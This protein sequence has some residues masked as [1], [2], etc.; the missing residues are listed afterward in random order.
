MQ[1]LKELVFILKRFQLKLLNPNGQQVERS[2][3]L[4]QLYDALDKNRIDTDEQAET[5]LYPDKKSGSKYRQLKS[6]L[7]ERMLNAI[8]SFDPE[9]MN[10]SDYQ[11]AYYECHKEW[12]V[13]KILSGQ[14]ANT[15][16]LSLATKLLKEVEFY[17]FS[18]L[19]VDIAAYLR[20]QYG[21]RESNDKKFNEYHH[22]YVFQQSVYEAECKAEEYYTF[23]MVKQVN[24]RSAKEEVAL[25]AENQ[26]DLI[27][28]FLSKFNTYKLHLY[29]RLIGLHRFTARNKYEEALAYCLE[30]VAFFQQKKYEAQVP[31][32]IFSYQMLIC[33]IQLRQFEEGDKVAGVCMNFSNEGTFNWFKYK[34]LYLQLSFHA[35]RFDRGAEIL[36]E[37]LAHPRFQFLPDNA[38]EIWRIY[39]SYAYFLFEQGKLQGLKKNS[40]KLGKFINDTPIFSKDKAGLN[41]AIIIIK[42]LYLLQQRK[43]G[44]L[45][46]EAEAIEHYCYRYLRNKNTLRSYYFIRMLLQ[47]PTGQFDVEQINKKTIKYQRL[48]AENPIS[49]ANQIYE[50]EIVPYEILWQLALESVQRK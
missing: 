2:S 23:L 1:D 34:E 30:T 29:G 19:A 32:Q 15:A 26:Y 20:F 17:E 36:Q 10:M 49:I 46:D 31:I 25:L 12:L 39:E 28:P 44:Q 4:G 16:A 41:I 38:K 47:I 7:R 13:V 33:H 43:L 50:I 22:I 11:K 45:L 48:L 24:N 37:V 3:M 40:F 8:A 5:L 6:V 9:G 42:Y 27:S 18:L 14:N 21:L 35:D